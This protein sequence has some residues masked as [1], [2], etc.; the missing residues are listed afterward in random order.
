MYVSRRW[1]RAH[2]CANRS[3]AVASGC[4]SVSPAGAA[5]P[6]LRSRSR[7]ADPGGRFA[8]G[9]SPFVLL[10]IHKVMPGGWVVWEEGK[11]VSVSRRRFRSV[12]EVGGGASLRVTVGGAPGEVVELTAL[13][14]TTGGLAGRRPGPHR[15]LEWTVHSVKATV[16]AGAVVTVDIAE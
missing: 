9:E 5:L 11:Y 1:D 15:G 2:L 8:P 3:A 6:D 7:S 4:V 16:G 12:E 13:R 10:A 14:P